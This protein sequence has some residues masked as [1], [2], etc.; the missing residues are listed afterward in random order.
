[1][2]RA[3]G[4]PDT[5]RLEFWLAVAALAA[6]TAYSF[7]YGFRAWRKNRTIEDT[8]RARVRSAAQ[9]YVELIGWGCLPEQ[10]PIKGPLTG[11]PCTWWSYQIEERGGAGKSRSWNTIDKGMS[12]TP[13]IFDDGTG[14]CWVDPRGAEV[15][16]HARTVWYGSDPW[17][18]FRLPPGQGIFGKLTD[19]LLS[20]GRYRYT[21]RRLQAREPMCALGEFRSHGGASVE[22][23]DAEAAALLHDWKQDQGKLL[24]RF[25]A[26]HD[27][28]I[29]PDE[30]ERARAAAREEVLAKRS[31]E[32][33]G[34]E[35][36]VLAEPGDGR[37]FLLA[38]SDGES[39]ARRFRLQAFA[40]VT[41]FVAA[42]AALTWILT[43]VR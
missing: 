20:G 23:A 3:S 2:I 4:N 6:A 29:G 39:L 40:S 9:G 21:E 22:S 12:E 43:N 36:H 19:A 18:Q 13:F 5:L 1:M 35:T 34:P 26:N 16:P 17:P 8:P 32:P 33:Q 27:G 37:A 42:A 31:A 24:A 11:I 25:D 28:V 15:V 7:W 10:S 41:C 30:W 38:A 14:Q